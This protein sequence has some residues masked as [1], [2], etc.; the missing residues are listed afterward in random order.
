MVLLM[1]AATALAAAPAG[2]GPAPSLV[3]AVAAQP[4]DRVAEAAR[5]L[6]TLDLLRLTQDRTYA[7]ATLAHLRLLLPRLAGQPA[8]AAYLEAM[9]A[10]VLAELD[11]DEEARALLSAILARNF[12]EP[13]P[14]LLVF[15]AASHIP[16]PALMVRGIEGA[17][18]RLGNA[19][20]GGMLMML[21][22][23]MIYGLDRTL[24]QENL[25]AE[26]LRL[27]E[28]L[29]AMNWQR[30]NPSRLDWFRMTLIDQ[31]LRENRRDE[32]TRL[33]STVVGPD[34]ITTLAIVRRYDGLLEEGEAAIR[35]ALEEEDRG[36]ASVLAARPDDVDTL[37]ERV[38]YLRSVG[39]AADAVALTGAWVGDVAAMVRRNPRGVWLVNETAYALVALDRV[40]EAAGLMARLAALDPA[41]NDELIG[42][43][44]NHA[45]LLWQIGRPADSLAQVARLRGPA[46][47]RANDYGRM[48][49]AA[50]AACSNSALGQS[51]EAQAELARL[52]AA[53]TVNA[54][55]LSLGLLCT[56]DLDG[57]ERHLLDRLAS[58][59][60]KQ[61][62]SALQDFEVETSGG[63]ALDEARLRLRQVRDRPA[64]R[65]AIDRVGRILTLPLDRSYQGTF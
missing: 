13:R 2:H 6:D 41:G 57:A 21:A 19:D 59:D 33:A 54:A 40:P 4:A 14:Y 10:L 16:D 20:H 63:P 24:R 65:A 49:I 42:P 60:P 7:E 22:P 23:E 1:L 56:N 11:R 26:R 8:R 51:V 18:R 29:V 27:A 55:A 30:A 5:A 34:T 39:R 62:L 9:Q 43:A 46:G 38:A 32:A 64:V 50:Y 48:W 61:V 44:I 37:I 35:R 31:R 25:A 47:E 28:A 58:D 17:A 45:G 53:P 15:A 3:S 36:T 52:K 12:D